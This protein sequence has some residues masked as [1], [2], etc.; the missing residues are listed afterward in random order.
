M[1]HRLFLLALLAAPSAWLAA[2]SSQAV[3][4]RSQ[5]PAPPPPPGATSGVTVSPADTDTGTQ[6]V[7]QPRSLPFKL[8]LSYDLQAYHVSNVDLVP[9]N[10]PEDG[11]VIVA[12]AVALRADFVSRPVGDGVLTPSVGFTAQRY[13]H[14]IGTG[15]HDNL[16]FDSYSVPLSLRYRFGDNWEAALG[17]SA[18]AVYGLEGPPSYHLL[19]R[20]YTP[21]LSLRKTIGLAP[22][23]LLGLGATLSYSDTSADRDSV[24]IVTPFRKDRNDKYEASADLAYYWIPGKWVVSPYARITWSDYLHYEENGTAPPPAPAIGVDRRDLTCSAGLSVTRNFNEWASARVFVTFDRRESLGDSAF[25]YG[26]K[27]LGAGVGLSLV[28]S[29]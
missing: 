4:D 27:N 6:R 25:D 11:A 2:Q 14:G 15:D 1:K 7:A 5:Q 9:D 16:D 17:F 13:C 18:S 26:Y 21:S 23:H 3:I 8:T 20:A 29:F 24:V 22:A 10:A 28:A 19:Y 12:N